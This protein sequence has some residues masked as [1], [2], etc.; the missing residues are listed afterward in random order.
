MLFIYT[1]KVKKQLFNLISF[2]ISW[3]VQRYILLG[4]LER[5]PLPFV[6]ISRDALP[7]AHSVTPTDTPNYL[8]TAIINVSCVLICKYCYSFIVI[9][10]SLTKKTFFL[11]TVKPVMSNFKKNRR[12]FVI[13]S[14]M[15]NLIIQN[16]WNT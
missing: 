1:Y 3:N 15:K 11:H 12:P 7:F 8:V 2:I 6:V 16:K 10:Y 5:K 9:I 13:L 14:F 4:R